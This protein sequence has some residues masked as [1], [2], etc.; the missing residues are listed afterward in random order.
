MTKV[1]PVIVANNEDAELIK[2]EGLKSLTEAVNLH[3]KKLYYPAF[4]L[5]TTRSLSSLHIS[6]KDSINFDHLYS[7]DDNDISPFSILATSKIANEKYPGTPILVL[8][9]TMLRSEQKDH[10]R[11]IISCLPDANLGHIITLSSINHLDVDAMFTYTS[12]ADIVDRVLGEKLNVSDYWSDYRHA[13]KDSSGE[14]PQGPA[15]LRHTNAHDMIEFMFRTHKITYSYTRPDFYTPW[16]TR[17][18]IAAFS[19]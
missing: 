7:I 18:E 16:Q 8:K 11:D 9:S 10:S 17:D 4:L 19:A 2:S 6:A 1:V 3:D 5:S 12:L 15:M 14:I 13:F